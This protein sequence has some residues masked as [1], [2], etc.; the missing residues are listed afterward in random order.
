MRRF[1]YHYHSE[2]SGFGRIRLIEINELKQLLRVTIRKYKSP[3]SSAM[4]A[5]SRR[6]V[7]LAGFGALLVVASA[8]D[9]MAQPTG[10]GPSGPRGPGG[11]MGG[12]P[13]MMGRSP[14]MM[15][16]IGD[17]A[18]YL[19]GIKAELSI[20]E[21]QSAGWKTYAD[22]VIGTATQMQAIHQSMWE[23]M[24]TATWEER[25][26]MMN[27]AFQARQQAFQA[28]HD[29]AQALLP[30]LTDLQKG[31]AEYI[32]PGL[33]RRGWHRRGGP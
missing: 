7:L 29:A 12:G 2:S 22:A 28:V 4:Q 25:R 8:G 10:P 1:R 27:H 26:D 3:R 33:A 24:G 23:A 16:H 18:A 30:S 5:I 6:I 9:T 11:M 17:P 31:K 19:N 20:T 14:G 13:D 21:A 32:L 15:G